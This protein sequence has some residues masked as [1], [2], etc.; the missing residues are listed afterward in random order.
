MAECS[1]RS[2]DARYLCGLGM[3]TQY[4]IKAAE[5]V[6]RLIGNEALLGQHHILRDATMTLAQNHAITPG[7]FWFG[8]S[9]P[10]DV[11]V[12]YA[13]DLDERH[14]RTHMAA[15]ATVQRP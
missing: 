7:P 6:E 4:R 3:A 10:Q 11:V 14:R 2:L 1:G 8:R 13:H 12:K 5:R 9:I 15:L